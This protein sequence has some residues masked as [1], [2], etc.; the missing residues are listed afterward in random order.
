MSETQNPESEIQEPEVE[1]MSLLELVHINIKESDKE[2]YD[3]IIRNSN[4]Q[5]NGY[6]GT[7]NLA[8]T[9]F[10]IG[11]FIKYKELLN[12]KLIPRPWEIVYY[13]YATKWFFQFKD[14]KDT[15]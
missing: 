7:L 4:G 6:V 5:F 10:K 2:Y 14:R 15:K 9:H 8:K 3:M 12:N 1:V 11:T 13:D